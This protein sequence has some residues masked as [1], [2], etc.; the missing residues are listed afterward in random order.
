MT[1]QT[2]D[3][4]AYVPEHSPPAGYQEPPKP[5]SGYWWE[6]ELVCVPVIFSSSPSA[7]VRW[8]RHLEAKGKPVFFPTVI[9]ARLDALLRKRGYVEALTWSEDF[10]EWCSGLLK[11]PAS[12]GA[13]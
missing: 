9:N 7:F 2:T 11:A 4:V 1:E 12:G 3:G 8:L 5:L 13:P 6:T 10:G